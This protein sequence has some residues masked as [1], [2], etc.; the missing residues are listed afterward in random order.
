MPCY[1]AGYAADHARDREREW[2]HN[3]PVAELLC[4]VMSKMDNRELAMYAP[5]GSKLW[6]WWQDHQ[7]RDRKKAAAVLARKAQDNRNRIIKI[8]RLE[9]ELQQLKKG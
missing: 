6:H 5:K 2:Q 8:E 9:K 7:E 4:G 1:D 3:S